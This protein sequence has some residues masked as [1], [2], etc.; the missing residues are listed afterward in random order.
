MSN[1]R[2]TDHDLRMWQGSGAGAPPSDFWSPMHSPVLAPVQGMPL[3]SGRAGLPGMADG[4]S[5]ASPMTQDS[6]VGSVTKPGGHSAS[7]AAGLEAVTTTALTAGAAA[8]MRANPL[9]RIAR[10]DEI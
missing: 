2:V 8:T 3:T 6:L 4:V 9:R 7:G 10:R 5:G 1:R